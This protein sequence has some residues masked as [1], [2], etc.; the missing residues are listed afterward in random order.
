MNAFVTKGA[1][2]SMLG[3]VRAP[4]GMDV[5]ASTPQEIAISILAEL[6][7]ERRHCRKQSVR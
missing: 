3:R 6:I 4:A 1:F 5:G 7:S 2:N